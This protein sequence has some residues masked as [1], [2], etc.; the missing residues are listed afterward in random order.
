MKKT[1]DW[2]LWDYLANSLKF[3]DKFESWELK[4]WIKIKE[5]IKEYKY[6]VIYEV[7]LGDWVDYIALL[8][9]KDWK[10]YYLGH[11][12]AD[13]KEWNKLFNITTINWFYWW[14]II[15]WLWDALLKFYL[16]KYTKSYQRVIIKNILD[17]S[18]DFW[19][20]IVEKYKK[21]WLIKDYEIIYKV[22]NRLINAVWDLVIEK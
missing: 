4:S 14:L 16:N 1:Y 3:V 12:T 21:Q 22:N 18:F 10:K 9:E 11:I 13:D 2:K 19:I 5:L 8:A 17:R 7:F 20:H 15:K 6:K